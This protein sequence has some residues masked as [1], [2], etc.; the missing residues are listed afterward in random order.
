MAARPVLRRKDFRFMS[1]A[2]FTKHKRFGGFFRA[3]TIA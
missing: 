2:F 3:Q 1:G